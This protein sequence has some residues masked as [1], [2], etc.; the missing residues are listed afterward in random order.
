M[1]PALGIE[2]Y[3]E[4]GRERYLF[5]DE[6]ERLG[7]AI[8]EAETNGIPWKIDPRKK[9]KH[10]P[11]QVQ[12]TKIGEHA[13]A[14]L[15]LLVFTG[16]R[17]GEILN[18]KWEHVDLERGLLLLPDS[19]TGK[20]AVILNAPAL[21][22]LANL[23]RVGSYVI[24]GES[25]GTEDEKAAHRSETPL[26][27]VRRH[28]GLEGIRLH[29]LRH[30]FAAFGAGGGLGL[31]IIGK[32]L[33]HSQPQ[34]TARYAHLDSDPW[35]RAANTIGVDLRRRWAKNKKW[36]KL[37]KLTE[38]DE[39]KKYSFDDRQYGIDAEGIRTPETHS[40]RRD[41]TIEHYVCLGHTNPDAEVNEHIPGGLDHLVTNKVEFRKHGVVPD[42]R[43]RWLVCSMRILATEVSIS[44]CRGVCHR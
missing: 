15:R 2:R 11:K 40:Y 7:A 8:R 38:D 32:L 26:A 9:I 25:A 16:A 6:L 3:K 4:D 37:P 5:V 14:A 35:R 29:D 13:A 24:A 31:P 43:S 41:P 18:L 28:A 39:S 10:T 27:V 42:R 23:S 19:R 17:V 30:N 22:I 1:K 20:K 21:A 36:R 34:T 33:G 12:A 44:R